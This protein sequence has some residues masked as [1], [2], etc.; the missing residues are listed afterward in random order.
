MHTAFESLFSLL[1]EEIA[2]Q[3]KVFAATRVQGEAA[4]ARDVKA[5]E[6]QTALLMALAQEAAHAE[7][8]RKRALRQILGVGADPGAALSDVIALAPE[9]CASRLRDLRKRLRLLLNGIREETRA[10]IAWIRMSLKV[11]GRVLSAAEPYLQAWPGGY[12][13]NGAIVAVAGQEPASS[14]M[15]PAL[16][17]QKG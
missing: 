4:R 13:A 8:A 10:N 1:E 16:I 9:P 14:A 11:V 6:E 15:R 12:A 7:A 5:L 3:E 2:R 17:D